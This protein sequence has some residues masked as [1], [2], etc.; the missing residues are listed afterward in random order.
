[1]KWL[2]IIFSC[3]SF[4]LSAQKTSFSSL[5]QAALIPDSAQR[6]NEIDKIWNDL[7]HR[8]DIPLIKGDSVIFLYRG[9]ASSVHWTGDFNGWGFNK[10]LNTTGQKISGT[11]IWFLK[12]SFPQNA[13]F[14]YKININGEKLIIDPE[15]QYHQWS[16]VGGGSIN[17]ELRMPQWKEDETTV[18][19]A[20]VPKGKVIHDVL[21]NSPALGYQIT[22]SVYLPAVAEPAKFPVIYVTD[23]YEYM[24]PKMGH[25]LT[26]LD[27]L[28]AGK[29]IKPVIA[30]FIDHREPINRSNNKRM[31]ELGMNAKYLQFFTD[32]L[33]PK[34]EATYSALPG[35]A[36]RAIMGT[37][38]GGLTAAY[39]V[40]AKP[41][42]FSMAGIQSPAFYTRPQIYQLCDN[43]SNTKIKIS[44]TS[45][46]FNDASEGG[47]K[48]KKIFETN[49][50]VYT[51]REVNEGHSWGNW[52]NLIDD[53]LID[54]F[55]NQ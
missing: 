34:I 27:N 23:G 46:V 30:V 55:G 49:A 18:E 1:M 13:R 48:M 43:P 15:N 31:E 40:F 50:C 10:K 54:L 39:F 41:D 29:K 26:V 19:K 9:D 8:G 35:A 14:D 36:N 21:I 24:H 51:Y 33:I 37:S 7:K 20:N 38:M 5:Q 3:F 6:K 11:N 17:S 44:M 47:Q 25:M 32:E 12:C 53:V 52:R 28:I 22:Y 4:T 2:I 16:G 45:G 42:V